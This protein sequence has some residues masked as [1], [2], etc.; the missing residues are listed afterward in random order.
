MQIIGFIVFIGVGLFQMAAII[1]G[2]EHWTGLPSIVSMIIAL[3]ITYI[4]LVGQVV[5]IL[6][7]MK[8]WGWEWWQA[9]ILFFGGLLM[10]LLIGGGAAIFHLVTAPF[11]R[12]SKN[13][14]NH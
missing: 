8:G 4:P 5:G 7:A 9:T 6:G 3:I 11:N 10:P 13:E 12:K 2:L 1:A 14:N